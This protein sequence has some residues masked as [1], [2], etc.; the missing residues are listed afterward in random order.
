MLG[1]TKNIIWK[2][3]HLFVMMICIILFLTHKNQ[4]K[5]NKEKTTNVIQ[6]TM[7]QY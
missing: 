6:N 7:Q 2:L 4:Q 5:M 1:G 3:I